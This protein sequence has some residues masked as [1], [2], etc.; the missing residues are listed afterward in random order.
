MLV[1]ISDLFFNKVDNIV[2]QNIDCC[3]S[4][5]TSNFEDIALGFDQLR[6]TFYYFRTIYEPS[7]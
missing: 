6:G 4:D 5:N 3:L 7:D 2:L 1:T